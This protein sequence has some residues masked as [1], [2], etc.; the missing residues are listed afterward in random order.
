MHPE[1][2]VRGPVS[3]RSSPTPPSRTHANS[4]PLSIARVANMLAVGKCI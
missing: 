3:T 2:I 1:Q 4:K